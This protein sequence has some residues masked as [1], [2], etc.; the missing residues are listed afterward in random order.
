MSG[1]LYQELGVIMFNKL[2]KQGRIILDRN[3]GNKDNVTWIHNKKERTKLK[4]DLFETPKIAIV[5]DT[6]KKNNEW[7]KNNL[8][9]HNL[10]TM[11]LEKMGYNKNELERDKGYIY[12]G[13]LDMSQKEVLDHIDLHNSYYGDSYF[14]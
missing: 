10:K 9:L 7:N 1:N 14:E 6:F 11:C 13:W 8:E 5:D 3:G 2:I 4:N 12:M